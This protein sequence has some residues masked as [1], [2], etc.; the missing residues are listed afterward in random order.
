MRQIFVGA[1]GMFF[2]SWCAAQSV[3]I[4]GKVTDA[5]SGEPIELATIYVDGSTRYTESDIEGLYQLDVPRGGKV[6]LVFSRLGYQELRKEVRANKNR[7]NI[8]VRLEPIESDLDVV[9][10]DQRTITDDMVRESV[11]D[12]KLLPSITG[13]IESVLPHI[14][15]GARSGT[16]GELS[17]QYN[18]RGGNYD[19]NLVYVNDFEIFRPQLLRSNQQEGLSFPNPDLIRDLSFSAGGYESRY[20]DKMS[21]VL[22]IYYK[23]PTSFKG[24]A[25][26]S[27]LGGSV[28]LEGSGLGSDEQSSR[29]RYLLGGRYKDTRYVLGSLDTDG[30]Y[31]PVF[32]DVQGYLTYDISRDLQVALLSNYNISTY[33]FTP[34]TRST[35]LGLIDFTL[36]LNSVFEGGESDQFKTGMVGTSLTYIPDR[37][38]NPFFIKLLASTYRGEEREAIDISG[39]YRLSQIETGAGDQNGQEIAVLGVGTQQQFSRNRLFNWSV[40]SIRPK[41]VDLVNGVKS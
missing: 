8:Y 34:L 1:I 33:D 36:Q 10:T 22:D 7:N 24:S 27:L 28:H 4:Q 40:K 35:G 39:F 9:V 18:V 3:T 15:L 37:E 31:S 2:C 21:S 25:T 11:E 20:G 13:N 12:I 6:I 5:D 26:A 32:A 41:P 38:Q 16:G 29:F 17:S 19:E 30:E 14:A 23:R